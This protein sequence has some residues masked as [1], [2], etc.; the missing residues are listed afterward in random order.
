MVL[1][2]WLL[3]LLTVGVLLLCGCSSEMTRSD[4]DV[5]AA[6]ALRSYANEEGLDVEAFSERV[7]PSSRGYDWIYE[8]Q[9]EVGA[10]HTLILYLKEGEIVERHRLV[11][12][13]N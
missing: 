6:S 3:Q 11:E 13:G 8:Y 1:K 7:T 2:L 12:K 4:A 9:S 5:L 10:R